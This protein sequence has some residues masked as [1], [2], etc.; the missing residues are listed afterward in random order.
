MHFNVIM[1]KMKHAIMLAAG[2]LATSFLLMPASR[3]L[4]LFSFE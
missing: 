4:T 1:S 3:L 2:L